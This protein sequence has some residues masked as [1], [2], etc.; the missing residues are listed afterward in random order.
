ML[1]LFIRL[2]FSPVCIVLPATWHRGSTAICRRLGLQLTL[3]YATTYVVCFRLENTVGRWPYLVD[4]FSVEIIGHLTSLRIAI[5]TTRPSS[6]SQDNKVCYKVKCLSISCRQ[7]AALR[8]WP[9]NIISS[10][11]CSFSHIRN[12][13]PCK[14]YRWVMA[15]SFQLSFIATLLISYS[16]IAT[17]AHF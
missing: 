17:R 5:I 3:F 13:N 16:M 7:R 15:S 12:F 1:L 11:Y 6:F 4:L 9:Q 14:T 2:T 10:D 8:C